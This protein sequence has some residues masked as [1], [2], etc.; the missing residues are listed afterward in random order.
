MLTSEQEMR[1]NMEI[2]AAREVRC[3]RQAL[4]AHVI[5]VVTEETMHWVARETMRGV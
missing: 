2:M 5:V 1:I 3:D 4:G